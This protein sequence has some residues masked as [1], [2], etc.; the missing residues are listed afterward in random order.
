[1][2]G[3]I[4]L[5]MEKFLHQIVF[6]DNPVQKTSKPAVVNKELAGVWVA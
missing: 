5:E 4:P 3:G 2:A 1:M 6:E